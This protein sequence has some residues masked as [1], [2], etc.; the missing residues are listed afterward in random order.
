MTNKLKYYLKKLIR[1]GFTFNKISN[2]LQK[3]QY[4]VSHELKELQGA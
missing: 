1:Q 4:F 2:E 3:S